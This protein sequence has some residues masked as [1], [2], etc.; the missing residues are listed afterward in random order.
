MT[1]NCIIGYTGFVGSNIV[2]NCK[3][4]IDEFYKDRHFMN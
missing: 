2:N 4:N 3:I 1:T